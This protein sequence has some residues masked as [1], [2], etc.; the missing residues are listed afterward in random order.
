MN[1]QVNRTLSPL[2]LLRAGIL[3]LVTASAY[4]DSVVF[5]GPGW[6]T[7]AAPATGTYE[8]VAYGAA[9]GGVD[10]PLGTDASGGDGAVVQAGFYLT[11][12]TTLTVV[13]GSKGGDGPSSILDEGSAGGGG[14]SVVYDSNGNPMLVAG[15]G[16]GAGSS[17][18]QNGLNASTS[19][20]SNGSVA[21]APALSGVNA[22]DAGSIGQGGGNGGI[23][24]GGPGVGGP[25]GGG[26]FSDGQTV[27]L[28]PGGKA[29]NEYTRDDFTGV[30]ALLDGA[31]GG[32][33]GG[34]AGNADPEN[35]DG[36][37]G[38]GGG[39]YGGGGGGGSTGYTGYGGGAGGSYS[40]D[41]NADFFVNLTTQNGEITIDQVTGVGTHLPSPVP[42]PSSFLFSTTGLF[43]FASVASVTLRRTRRRSLN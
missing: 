41:P 16:G 13:L 4:A 43:A 25:G 18:G 10:H 31:N 22:S 11:Q 39:G 5:N 3:S 14:A 6:T 24:T 33:N 32:Y 9:G 40:A 21:I 8:I 34:G 28:G 26:L 19:S 2:I 23:N 7:W 15:G 42:E 35:D 37:G 29:L 12:G 30:A 36:F 1:T 20:S 38:A 27:T 17:S